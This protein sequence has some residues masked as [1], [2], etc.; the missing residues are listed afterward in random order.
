M[1]RDHES[2]A[3]KAYNELVTQR[4]P[5]LKLR[6]AGFY[7]GDPVYLG[8]SPDGVL[9]NSDGNLCGII[10]IKC[11]YSAANLSVHETCTALDCYLDDNN[12]MSCYMLTIKYYYQIQ[13]TMATTNAIFGD[14]VV[15]TPKSIEC[16]HISFDERIWNS[17]HPELRCF[18]TDYML[19]NILY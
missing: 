4:H 10:E 13:G 3:F 15:W 12:T 19:P 18:Y 17:I 2:T 11:P 6:K 9:E 16:V 8:A 5:N 14:F 1:G 7:I